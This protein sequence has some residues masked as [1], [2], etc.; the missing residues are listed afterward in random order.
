[1]AGNQG[2]ILLK[3]HLRK[4]KIAINSFVVGNFYLQH[5]NLKVAIRLLV[6]QINGIFIIKI[7]I[8][9]SPTFQM[10]NFEVNSHNFFKTIC[11]NAKILPLSF[12]NMRAK[13][14]Y[15]KLDNFSHSN[16]FVFNLLLS[17]HFVLDNSCL[18]QAINKYYYFY[19]IVNFSSPV[20]LYPS[21]FPPSPILQKFMGGYKQSFLFSLSKIHRWT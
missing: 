14:S 10:Q 6:F 17:F 20:A 13:S 15:Q 1:M 16:N 11:S 18:Y 5:M 2:I 7:S 12:N 19:F 3:S 8:S 9:L 21:I 4:C